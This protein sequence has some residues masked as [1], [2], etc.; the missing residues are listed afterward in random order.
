MA[1]QDGLTFEGTLNALYADNTS[2]AISEADLRAL[3]TAVKESYL[4][5]IDDAYTGVFPQFTTSTSTTAFAGTPSPAITAY[6]T[7]QKF[8]FKAHATST[9]SVTLNLAA[10]GAKKLYTNPTTQ[11]GA[12]DLV[13][14]QVY[15]GVY[16]AAL[17]SATGGF[18]LIGGVASNFTTRLQNVTSSATVTPNASTDDMVVITAQAEAL[19]LANPSGTST[20]GQMIVIRVKDDGTARAI[21]YGSEYRAIGLDLTLPSTTVI[22]KT[23]YMVIVRNT[24]DTK[25]DMINAIQEA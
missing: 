24:T 17:D 16:D 23:L 20:Q 6:A 21:T 11:A 2:N 25:W 10:I 3:P 18:I 4:N 12:G 19:L 1:A 7:G 9:G 22:S 13:I 5:R 8:Q 15:I 14:N